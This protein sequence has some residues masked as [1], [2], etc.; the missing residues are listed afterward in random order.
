[1]SHWI[2]LRGLAREARHWGDFPQQLAAG[3][4]AATM[5]APDIPGNGSLFRLASPIR[6]EAMVEHLRTDLQMRQIAPP[7][8][9]LALSLGG[10]VAVAWAQTYPEEIAGLVLINT[11]LRPVNPWYQRLQPRS[12][13]TL[14]RI[15]LAGGNA[16]LREQLILDLTSNTASEK[17]ALLTQWIAWRKEFPVSTANALRQI[18]AASLYRAPDWAPRPPILMLASSADR[19]VDARCTRQL[20]EQW[21]SAT[22]LHPA[23]GHDLPL[24]DGPWVVG[25][26]QQWLRHRLK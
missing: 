4:G 1:M 26:V 3:I 8:H 10:M 15:A 16:A 6:I 2:L 9:L 21:G 11:S 23:A 18:A 19:L 14:L 13:A 24:D 22:A 12:Y 7:Y 17:T 20:A 5:Y 25:Q